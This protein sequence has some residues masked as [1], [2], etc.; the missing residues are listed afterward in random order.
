[1]EAVECG[2]RLHVDVEGGIFDDLEQQSEGSMASGKQPSAMHNIAEKKWAS[3][4]LGSIARARVNACLAP[5]QSH[6]CPNLIRPT[7]NVRFRETWIELHRL[8]GGHTGGRFD[9]LECRR[10]GT[11]GREQRQSVGRHALS[12]HGRH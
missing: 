1:M 11:G 7:D 12:E 6:W 10:A 8:H 2:I 9:L 5:L 3:T 4:L